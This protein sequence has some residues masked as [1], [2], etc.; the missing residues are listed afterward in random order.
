M[1]SNRIRRIICLILVFAFALGGMLPPFTNKRIYAGVVP[2]DFPDNKVAYGEN[3]ST[4]HFLDPNHGN[5]NIFQD[6]QY[7]ITTDENGETTVTCTITS[8][9]AEKYS[10][11]LSCD[12][13]DGKLHHHVIEKDDDGNVKYVTKDGGFRVNIQT[14][15]DGNEGYGGLGFVNGSLQ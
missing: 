5:H 7:S 3:P 14:T 10:I 15:T 8:D 2:D 12:G 4:L 11:G 6:I 1:K 13:D 9:I